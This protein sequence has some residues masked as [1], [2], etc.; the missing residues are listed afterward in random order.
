[1]TSRRK[2]QSGQSSGKAVTSPNFEIPPKFEIPPGAIMPPGFDM[3]AAEAAA[4]KFQD[5]LEQEEKALKEQFPDGFSS[6]EAH[7]R[8]ILWLSA[9]HNIHLTGLTEAASE[10]EADSWAI[11]LGK[12]S[13]ARSIIEGIQPF[14]P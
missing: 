1:M 10:N 11:D 14:V 13:A 12:V 2:H 9:L 7:A 5:V 6:M 8:A 3:E 4:M